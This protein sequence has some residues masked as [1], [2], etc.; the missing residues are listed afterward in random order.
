MYPEWCDDFWYEDFRSDAYDEYAAE[1]NSY[2]TIF[3][4]WEIDPK[5]LKKIN[6]EYEKAMFSGDMYTREEF[7]RMI[8]EGLFI[9]YDGKGYFHDGTKE[10][11]ISVWDTS[12]TPE[13]VEKY[14]YVVW[15]NK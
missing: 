9:P 1:Q 4:A 15:Y 13:D 6:D 11:N 2:N 7:G 12:L 14:P 10:T 8:E 3:D 5:E